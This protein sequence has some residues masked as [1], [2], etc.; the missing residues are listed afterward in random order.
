MKKILFNSDEIKHFKKLLTNDSN[1]DYLFTFRLVNLI[2]PTAFVS[3]TLLVVGISSALNN[4]SFLSEE[5]WY[6]IYNGSFP[7]L[8]INI[9]LIALFSWANY[10]KG[11]EK[12]YGVDY[13]NLRTKLSAYLVI[14]L[15]IGGLLYFTQATLAPVHNNTMKVVE[16]IGSLI[17]IFLAWILSKRIILME[18]DR[19]SNAYSENYKGEKQLN[20]RTPKNSLLLK[21]I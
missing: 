14:L 13:P 7:L 21:R 16:I 8:G 17:L 2:V 18:A 12:K 15:L 3:L 1:K 20:E 6:A 11:I 9:L 4:K 19:L 5:F 10:D